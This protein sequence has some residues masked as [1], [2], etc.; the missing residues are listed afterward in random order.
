MSLLPDL[1]PLDRA[2]EVFLER[3]RVIA[4]G[5]WGMVHPNPMVGC[6]LVKDGRVVSEAYH[7]VFGGSHAEVLALERAGSEAEGTTAYVSLEPCNH[8]KRG[9]LPA[10]RRANE[11]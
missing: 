8:S 2:D 10:A 11:Y 6:V 5:G 4:Q 3:A 9:T 1:V 7:E